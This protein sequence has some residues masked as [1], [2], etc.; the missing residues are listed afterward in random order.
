MTM[1]LIADKHY[2]LGNLLILTATDFLAVL[3]FANVEICISAKDN[4]CMF[5]LTFI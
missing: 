1:F 4:V 5:G 3:C 2:D